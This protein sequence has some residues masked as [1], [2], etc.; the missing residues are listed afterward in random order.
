[1]TDNK[2]LPA[3]RYHYEDITVG[4]WFETG[5]MVITESHI[6]QFAG[7]S[8]DFFDIHMDDQFA[9]DDGFEGRVAHGLLGLVLADGLKNRA[10]TQLAAIASLGWNSWSFRK[11]IYIGT[12]IQA[13]VEIRSKRLTSK[14]DRG[15]VG[16]GFNLKDCKGDTIQEGDNLLLMR[17]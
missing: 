17:V 3:G 10:S 16:L 13:R 4:N 2:H 1:M 9:R 15:I 8:G 11:P 7:L 12:T 14:G 6:V 5:R